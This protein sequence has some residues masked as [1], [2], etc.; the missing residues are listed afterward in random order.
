MQQLAN[1][2]LLNMGIH[3]DAEK[4]A[5]VL[6][7]LHKAINSVRNDQLYK[8]MGKRPEVLLRKR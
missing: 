2:Q 3:V 1:Q 5:K 8:E 6:T 4:R 7:M